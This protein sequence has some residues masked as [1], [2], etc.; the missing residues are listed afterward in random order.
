MGVTGAAAHT[1]AVSVPHAGVTTGASSTAATSIFS[2]VGA[3]DLPAES[4]TKNEMLA[5]PRPKLFGA[6]TNATAELP[7]CTVSP[8]RI[9]SPKP[10]TGSQH[11][12]S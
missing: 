5:T 9:S 6:G 2:V 1:P 10:D 8:S 7:S 12:T 11:V 3:E 4:T